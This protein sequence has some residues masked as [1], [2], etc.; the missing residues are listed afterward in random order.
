[1]KLPRDNKETNYEDYT[2]DEVRIALSWSKKY[3]NKPNRL[4]VKH[5]Y[6]YHQWL[7]YK[8]RVCNNFPEHIVMEYYNY[9]IMCY[10]FGI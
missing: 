1:M 9:W 6:I 4:R 2:N 8:S 5:P 3:F 10:P 7:D